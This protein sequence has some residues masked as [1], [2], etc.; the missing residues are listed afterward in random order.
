MT[1]IEKVI[2]GLEPHV[3]E[4]DML[5]KSCPF[6]EYGDDCFTE[7]LVSALKQLRKAKEILDIPPND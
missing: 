2:K 7:L 4:S 1:E 3:E 5:C 6:Y